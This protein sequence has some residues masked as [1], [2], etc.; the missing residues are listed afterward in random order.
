MGE[1]E[2]Q[3]KRPSCGWPVPKRDE[4][5][6]Q[7]GTRDCGSEERVYN[8]KGWGGW[9]G[10]PRETPI[11]EKHL[12]GA[13]KKWKVDSATPVNPLRKALRVTQASS[14]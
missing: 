9:T 5:G 7:V 1:S 6:K 12:P 4:S 11:C 2:R 8:V 10:R 14:R 3:E 13:W